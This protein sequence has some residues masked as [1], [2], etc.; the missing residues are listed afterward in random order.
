MVTPLAVKGGGARHDSAAPSQ[1]QE[2]WGGGLYP[3]EEHR[4]INCCAEETFLIKMLISV[5][6]GNSW[7]R[8][9]STRFCFVSRGIPLRTTSVKSAKAFD[10]HANV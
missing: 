10:F 7:S 4:G 5:C 9:E 2:E 3:T 1:G 8:F 6:S